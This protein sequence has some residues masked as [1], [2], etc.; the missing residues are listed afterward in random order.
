LAPALPLMVAAAEDERVADDVPT[1]D[2]A[3]A[4]GAA[5]GGGTAV[6]SMPRALLGP[7]SAPRS[8]EAVSPSSQASPRTPEPSPSASP[9]PS[10]SSQERCLEAIRP[11][12]VRRPPAVP[13]EETGEVSGW[14]R[15]P[16]DGRMYAVTS[17]G[18]LVRWDPE[19]GRTD[20]GF[21]EA[22]VP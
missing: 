21:P 6:V 3:A 7:T 19:T 2:G 8:P 17:F 13:A 5:A 22:V 18:S 12:T 4:D 1:A 10:S 20:S 15:H 9:A 16:G 14:A 11:S